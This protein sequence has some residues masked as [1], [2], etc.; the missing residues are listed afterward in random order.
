MHH[1]LSIKEIGIQPYTPDSTHMS[2]ENTHKLMGFYLEVLILGVI[3]QYMVCASLTHM[4]VMVS[5]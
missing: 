1:G 4:Q 3:V 2:P 5:P